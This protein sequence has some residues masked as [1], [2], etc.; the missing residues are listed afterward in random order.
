MPTPG[1]SPVKTRDRWSVLGLSLLLW[2]LV[3]IKRGLYQS[4]RLGY[5]KRTVNPL[6]R[7]VK[8]LAKSSR[9]PHPLS[10]ERVTTPQK[11]LRFRDFIRK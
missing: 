1:K 5:G 2:V 9:G 8:P 10:R 11:S 4:N 6:K 3:R 7:S